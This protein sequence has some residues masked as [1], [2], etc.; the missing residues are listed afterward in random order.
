MLRCTTTKLLCPT[1]FIAALFLSMPMTGACAQV[2]TF[3]FDM[4]RQPLGQA[5]REYARISGEQI[6]FTNDLVQGRFAPALHGTFD[7]HDALTQL[8]SGS[9]L[10]ADHAPSGG[11]MIREKAQPRAENSAPDATVETV[12]VT[13]EK[14]AEP[15]KEVP[16]SISVL[17]GEQL[18]GLH[19]NS[20]N[21]YFSLIPGLQMQSGGLPGKGQ[22][23]IR[24][25]NSGQGQTSAT[26]GFYIDDAPV[27]S[28]SPI[29]YGA[30]LLPEIDPFDLERVEVL[31]GPQGTLYG[32]GSMG[33]LIKFV[34]VTPDPTS[35]SGAFG[36]GISAVEDGGIGYLVHGTVNV[37]LIQDK[38]ALRVTGYDNDSPGWVDNVA[39]GR[40]NVNRAVTN[41]GRVAVGAYI[42]DR[43]TIQTSFMYQGTL[44][45]GEPV[46]DVGA[47]DPVPVYGDLKQ[48]RNVKERETID[49]VRAAATVTY[50]F[51]WATLTSASSYSTFHNGIHKDYTSSYSPVWAGLGGKLPSAPIGSVF[52]GNSHIQDHRFTQEV[53]LASSNDQPLTWLV[54]AYYDQENFDSLLAIDGYA[55][56]GAPD[57]GIFQAPYYSNQ[58]GTYRDEA[59]FTNL[60]YHFNSRFDVTGGI[61]YSWNRQ[62]LTQVKGGLLS[63]LAPGVFVQQTLPNV[64][65]SSATY[66]ADARYHVDDNTMIYARVASGY[67][68]GSAQTRP[69]VPAGAQYFIQP[70]TL[71]NYEAGAKSTLL[72]G[73]L[74]I[75]A[76]AY[77]ISWKNILLS[78]RFAGL[79]LLANGG[80]AVSKG[81]EWSVEYRPLPGLQLEWNGDYDIAEMTR[82]LSGVSA[83][84]GDSLPFT[85][86]WQTALSAEY[87]APISA[88]A[89]WFAGATYRYVGSR[90]S[91][92]AQDPL[93][94][95]VKMAAYNVLDLRTGVT[96]GE[97][98]ISAYV[99]N[100][101][102]SRG[103]IFYFQPRYAASQK[104]P[105]SVEPIQ[106]RTVGL[107]F[108]AN[109]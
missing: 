67:R 77:Y 98:E 11:E 6:I 58:Q 75:D 93:N 8:L 51:D 91:G 74:S 104:Q 86:K 5:L 70:D 26:V 87:T 32:A 35:F 62:T 55:S 48:Y 106:P 29:T 100:L 24:G 45:D 19:A 95:G 84:P 20:L 65:S 102:D 71:W 46:E 15:L 101:T 60:T 23:S 31:R 43:L 38:L 85:P 40:N 63:S 89:A 88:N 79:Q 103:W 9:G 64:N 80:D 83:A 10:V 42:N 68:P 4:P 28:D 12:L 50:D 90:M 41:G 108:T 59:V 56:D 69:N 107:T 49:F 73:K 78:Q 94:T 30:R 37:P 57:K 36:T 2:Q 33:G 92:F 18:E 47:T 81:A 109:F 72:D 53:R 22:L 27:G 97:Y 96:F 1:A 54:A 44:S 3:A 17:T 13:A 7:A 16:S 66:L 99:Q 25:I 61:R 39:T 76:D 52:D 14:R 21:D 82:V 105:A 34:T